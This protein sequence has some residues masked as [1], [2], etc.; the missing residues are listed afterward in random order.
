M[1]TEFTSAPIG[2]A[3]IILQ[4]FAT[5]RPKLNPMHFT[6][7]YLINFLQSFARVDIAIKLFFEF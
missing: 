5:A 6:N 4:R 3:P 7:K 2:A 1:P